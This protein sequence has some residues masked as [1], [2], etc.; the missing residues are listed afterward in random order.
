MRISDWSSDVCS[1]DLSP[2]Y[3]LMENVPGLLAPQFAGILE[4]LLEAYHRSGYEVVTPIRVL[5][6]ADFG[7]PQSRERLILL[8]YRRGER[9]PAYPEPTH[10]RQSG[11]LLLKRTPT[12][13]DPLAG[14]PLADDYPE[15]LECDEELG[16]ASWRERGRP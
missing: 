6:A 10:S 8:I 4:G 16:S 9:P 14:L 12:V 5:N 1:S 13:G 3:A 2:R 15:L 7:V 11:D